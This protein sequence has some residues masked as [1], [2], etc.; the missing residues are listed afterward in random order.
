M[1]KATIIGIDLAKESSKSMRRRRT[2]GRCCA[3]RCRGRNCS[4]SWLSS[5]PPSWRWKRA[6]RRTI[7]GRA[8]SSLG[9][10][11]RLVPPIYVKPFARRQKND[12]ADA[13]AIAEAASRPTMRF[14][15]LKT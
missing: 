11:V 15:T 7:W 4:A 14:V 6:R 9:H 8:I 12:A 10:D 5:R 13:E 2:D 3:R 1:E